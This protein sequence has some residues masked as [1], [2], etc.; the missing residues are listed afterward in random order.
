MNAVP[1]TSFSLTAINRKRGISSPVAPRQ[2]EAPALI[3]PMDLSNSAMPAVASAEPAAPSI[4]LPFDPLRVIDA[5]I[6]RW[7]LML[8][9]GLI[10]SAAM[11]AV[12]WMRFETL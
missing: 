3:E 1:P 4:K 8:L 7:W 9:A 12:G 5:L 10:F 6:R 11:L 2:R